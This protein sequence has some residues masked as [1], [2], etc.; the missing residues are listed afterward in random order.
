MKKIKFLLLIILIFLTGCSYRELNELAIGSALGID[1]IN[2]EYLITVQVLNLKK[3]GETSEQ[4]NSIIY[5]ATGKTIA[6]AIRNISLAYPKTIYFG[7]LELVIL[8]NSTLDKNIGDLFDFF[9]RSPE[10]RDDFDVIV[11]PNGSANEILD[12][13]EQ[14]ANSFP[15]KEIVNTIENSM[16]KQGSTVKV[17]MEELISNYLQK[18][19]DPVLTS[20]ERINNENK[21]TGIIAFDDDKPGNIVKSSTESAMAYNLIKENFYDILITTP[22]KDTTVDLL[23]MTPKTNI[24]MNIKKNN[25]DIVINIKTSIHVSEIKIPANLEDSDV[26][27]EIQNSI[28]KTLTKYVNSLLATCKENNIDILGLK[29]MIYK[30]HHSNYKK[31]ADKNIYE[32]ANIKVK[33]TTEL[34]RYGNLYRSS[35]GE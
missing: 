1:Y 17:N 32:I 15:S 16:S 6:G 22:Y 24:D 35:K 10:T 21:L 31:Y 11:N 8:G 28:N 14:K 34:Y 23:I 4:E 29:N 2:N 25:I 27:K 19:L 26:Q 13:V 33:V 7:H 30:K 5:K 20:I 9:I 12:P 3:S 18:G